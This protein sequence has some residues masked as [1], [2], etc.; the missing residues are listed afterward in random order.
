MPT[1]RLNTVMK[2]SIVSERALR[3]IY[4][5]VFEIALGIQKPGCL[6]TSYNALNGIYLTESAEILQT[7]VRG[8]WGFDGMIMTDWCS[9]DTIDP[10]EIVKAG[11]CWLTEGGGRY[12]NILKKAVKSGKLSEDILRDNAKYVIAWVLKAMK[13]AKK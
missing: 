2:Y 11:T 12:V 3:E 10:V 5:R 9:Y 8:E 4:F 6:M 1:S 7:L 13:G